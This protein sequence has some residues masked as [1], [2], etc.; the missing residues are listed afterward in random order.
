MPSSRFRTALA[1]SLTVAVLVGLPFTIVARGGGRF[2]GDTPNSASGGRHRS[3]LGKSRSSA[4]RE[5]CPRD[6]QGKGKRDP[7]AVSAFK[8][9]HA[10]SHGR[11]ARVTSI[12]G[13]PRRVVERITR[14]ERDEN[15]SGSVD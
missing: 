13:N 8:R 3:V 9:T 1:L 14:G 2:S 12:V 10:R 15:K 7:N 5:R 6:R 4:K 11:C